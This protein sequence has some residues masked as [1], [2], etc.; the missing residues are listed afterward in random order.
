[1]KMRTVLSISAVICSSSLGAQ[2]A[3]DLT[4]Y[5][6]ADR[7]AEIALARTAA[8]P[9]ISANATVLVL[10][11]KGYVQA[12]RGNN[13]F[14]CAVMRSFA[15]TPGDPEFWKPHTRAP[16]CFNPP[17]ARTVLPAILA[18]IDWAIAGATSA[19]MIGRTKKGYAEKRFKMPAAGAM[20]YMLS[21]NQHLSDDDPQWMPHLMFFYERSLDA[22]AF[23]AGGET[24]PIVAGD[25]T[26]PVNVIYIPVRNWS[27]GSAA[28]HTAPS[29]RR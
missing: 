19:E 17:G 5:L 2:K 1:M 8:P 4:P 6:I 26:A 23:G 14:T 20:A 22:A 29:V 7:T 28:V 24:A 3:P 12:A 21:P 16:L 11:P 9:N 10:T 25:P 27:D 18:Q 13:G 15:G